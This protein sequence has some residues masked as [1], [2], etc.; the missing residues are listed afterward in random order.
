MSKKLQTSK[1]I[2]LTHK[3]IE[4]LLQGED[5]PELPQNVSFVPFSKTDKKLNKANT[6]LLESLS[7][8]EKP[9]AIA[10]EP[11][12]KKDSWKIIPVNF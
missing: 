6:E 7:Q 2:E 12:N 4:Y 3:L 8:E 5:V 10:Q 1:N 9:L 11:Q